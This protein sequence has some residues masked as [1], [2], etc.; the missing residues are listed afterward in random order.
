MVDDSIGLGFEMDLASDAD[1]A[2]EEGH[3][4][5]VAETEEEEETG[6]DPE[7]VT[8]VSAPPETSPLTNRIIRRDLPETSSVQ[9][10]F[11]WTW[12]LIV[13]GYS[14]EHIGQTRGIDRAAVFDHANRALQSGRAVQV[15][16]LLD[17]EKVSVLRQLI[18]AN[19]DSRMPALLAQLPAGIESFEL[20]F[21]MKANDSSNR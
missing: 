21:F 8:P 20:Q 16:W 12:Q 13:D 19:P 1:E 9:P 6:D 5:F 18:Q 4:A 2:L 17:S 14:V 10:S 3:E 7:I 15:D 11:Y